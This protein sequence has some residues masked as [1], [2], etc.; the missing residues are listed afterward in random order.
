MLMLCNVSFILGT[1]YS[2]AENR[3]PLAAVWL[4]FW[5]VVQGDNGFV[6]AFFFFL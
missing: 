1:L 6:V 5:K 4:G 2:V 3:S